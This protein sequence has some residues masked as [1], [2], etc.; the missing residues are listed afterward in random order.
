MTGPTSLFPDVPLGECFWHPG[1]PF[2]M[3]LALC[4]ADGIVRSGAMHHGTNYNCTGGAHYDGAHI[5]CTSAAHPHPTVAADALPE[6]PE[7]IEEPLPEEFERLL[8]DPEIAIAQDLAVHRVIRQHLRA[9]PDATTTRSAYLNLW[10]LIETGI[11]D[12]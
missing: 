11:F 12:A 4:D 5:R 3:G 7:R 2:T 10:A 1:V 9:N 6:R 8:R